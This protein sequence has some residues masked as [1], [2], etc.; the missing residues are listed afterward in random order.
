MK[1]HG[2]VIDCGNCEFIGARDVDNFDVVVPVVDETAE[3]KGCAR[4]RCH[5]SPQTHTVELAE[6]SSSDDASIIRLDGEFGRHLST[7]LDYV[8]ERRLCG[9]R[10]LCPK[11]VVNIVAK[12][13]SV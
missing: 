1:K 10:T 5:V 9:N 2:L 6:W 7:A 8:A 4:L 11:E 13:E 3:T 12:T